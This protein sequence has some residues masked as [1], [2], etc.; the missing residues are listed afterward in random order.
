MLKAYSV[1]KP[2]RLSASFSAAFR[3]LVTAVFTAKSSFGI[4]SVSKPA[5]PIFLWSLVE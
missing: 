4:A 3:E 2:A 5:M 1:S